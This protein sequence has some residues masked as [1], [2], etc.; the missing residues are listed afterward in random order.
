[1]GTPACVS[2][3]T[4]AGVTLRFELDMKALFDYLESL[5]VT[6]GAGVGSLLKLLPWQKRFV[7]GAFGPGVSEAALSVARGNGKTV[8]LAA[9]ACA[10][11]DGPLRTPHG[12]VTI[13]AASFEQGR[14]LGEHVLAFMGDKLDDRRTWRVWD[15]AQQFRL[16]HRQTGA[17]VSII[18]SDPRR[19]HGRTGSFWLDEPAQW[20]PTGEA[21]VAALRTALGKTPGRMIALG[22]RPASDAHWFSEMLT[23]GS[24]YSQTHAAKADDPVFQRRTWL[25]ANPSLPAMPDLEAAI[26]R[27]AKRARRD[28]MILQ[29][30]K[31]LRLNLGI[32]D[33]AESML[34]DAD[35]WAGIEGD[36]PR[37]GRYS[38]GI[39][40]GTSS[41][42]SGAAAFWGETGRLESFACFPKLPSLL[43]RGNTDGVG[44][45]YVRMAERNEL[46]QAGQN[47]S[48]IP[49]LLR[50]VLSRWGMPSVIIADRWREVEL[51][52]ALEAARFPFTSLVIRGQGWRD[53]SQDVREFRRAVLDDKVVPVESLL[54]RSAMAEAR[55]A[56][57]VAG[58][59]KLAKGAEGGRRVRARDD[60][61][62]A[63]ILAIAEGVR[64]HSGS[65]NVGPLRLLGVVR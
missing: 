16:Q 34:L 6:Q 23:G 56:V 17:R 44:S 21:M 7:R 36:A 4:E 53:G 60:A 50:E 32:S 24:D 12:Q 31:A 9:C 62:A 51:K 19:A 65:G 37:E 52:Q 30:F 54:L 40:C 61:V 39:D 20:P 33:V 26:R 14:I 5:R 55:V 22:T 59:A 43:E 28:P 58:N 18:G 10:A 46:I 27:E 64:R 42:M 8:L 25:K 41:A 3:Q 63:A 45:L 57:D 13:V 11:L 2:G 48:D 49:Q 38:L 35:T 29:S 1:M 47:V 15:T